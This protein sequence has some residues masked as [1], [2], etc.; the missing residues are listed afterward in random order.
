MREE[1][2]VPTGAKPRTDN[3]SGYRGVSWEKS[4][5]KWAAYIRR[6][7]RRQFLGLFE[8][9]EAASA[10]YREADERLRTE[11]PDRRSVLLAVAQQLYQERGPSGLATDFLNKSGVSEG[12]LR[13]VGLSHAGLLVELNLTDEYRRWQKETFT[14]AGKQKPRWNW[15]RAVEVA[16]ELISVQGDLP[17]VQWCRL[18]G[19]SQLTNIVHRLGRDWEDLRIE[20][21]LPS[22]VMKNGRPRYFDSRIGVRW[23]SRPEACLSNFLYARGIKH[24]RGERYPDDYAK[25]S[26]RKYGRYDL[27]FIARTGEQI[28]V[29]IWGDIPDAFSKGRY[30]VTR[31]KKEAY[32]NG[33]HNF[34]A[35]RY[36]DC[37]SENSLTELLKAYIGVIEPFQFDKP[38]DRQ[39]ETAHWSDADE[40]LETCREL[41]A[42]MP[43]GIFPNEQW[44]RK[45]GKCADRPG[46]AYNTLS[47]YVQTMLGG[48]RN[49]RKLLG[50]ADANTTKWTPETVIEAWRKFEM[51]HGMTPAKCKG[52]SRRGQADGDVVREGA[53]IYEAAR[54]LGVVD[55]AR[56][57]QT[58]RK[59]KWTPD[60]TEEEWKAFCA[61]IARLPTQ[62]M[63]KSQRGQLPRS[64]TDRATRI[65]SAAQRLG[66]LEKL[67]AFSTARQGATLSGAVATNSTKTS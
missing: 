43:D 9:P 11:V 17:T 58:G 1:N 64:I 53:R 57:G 18:N 5:R 26:G 13:R 31:S 28:D 3:T 46:E 65:Y 8:T 67:R 23:R 56:D 2:T 49:V 29:E 59:R 52:I 10:A 54:R 51:D 37:Q 6:N 41:A 20:G 14:Y 35:L 32:H 61:E 47:R 44:L 66:M 19:Y 55:L 34:L 38:Q 12:K 25:I 36:L 22:T 42:S 48:A 7:G 45:R 21:C 24:W 40:I 60:R 63:S 50:Q 39:I 16:R 4:T 30:S 15:E 33:C 27:H 62:C